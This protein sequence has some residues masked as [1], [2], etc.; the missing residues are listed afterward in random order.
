M[1][2]LPSHS[3]CCCSEILNITPLFLW[4]HS[5]E[6]ESVH[7]DNEYHAT[8]LLGDPLCVGLNLDFP[9]NKIQIHEDQWCVYLYCW[10]CHGT[11]L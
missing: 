1:Y 8:G 4:F 11:L 6:G 9:A 10:C 2:I 5:G 3:G 7:I